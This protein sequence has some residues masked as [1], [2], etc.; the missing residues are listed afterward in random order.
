V[1]GTNP[2]ILFY[3]GNEGRL[4]S[5]YDNS[6]YITVTLAQNLSALIIFAEHRYYGESMPFGNQ[7]FT[8][9]N[10]KYLTV[11][12]TM[13]DY[14]LLI[15]SI[16]NQTKYANSPVIAFGG[17]YG[18]MLASW[19]RMKYPHIIYGAHAASAPILFFPGSVSPY[20]FNDLVTRT[21]KDT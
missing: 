9:D 1:N 15:K 14:V 4:E 10:V 5:F 12:Q 13:M 8:P 2:P 6:G 19:M 17:S 3:C 18:G 21:F 20:A 7:S 16:K 11:D